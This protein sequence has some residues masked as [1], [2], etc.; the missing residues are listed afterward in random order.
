MHRAHLWLAGTDARFV[1]A[2]VPT[3]TF[4]SGAKLVF[5]HGETEKAIRRYYGSE[6]QYIGWDE[7]TGFPEGVLPAPV[8]S[9]A[10]AVRRTA[11][12]AFRSE[13]AA[14]ATPAVQGIASDQ[15]TF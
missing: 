1:G 3:Y 2:P 11:F 15:E 4:P 13:C 5:G 7:L 8:L 12:L 9:S 6:W 10:Q 14:P